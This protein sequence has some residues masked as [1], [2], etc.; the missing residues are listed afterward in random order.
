MRTH[1]GLDQPL[2]AAR[3][4]LL[5]GLLA[6]LGFNLVACVPQQVITP[7]P[8]SHWNDNYFYNYEPPKKAAPVSIRANVIIVNPS[9]KEAESAFADATYL[10]V[11]KGFSKSMGVDLDKIMVAKG[12][13]VVG[14]HATLDDVTYPDKKGADLTLAP[15]V[16][17]TADLKIGDSDNRIYNGVWHRERS[18]MMKIGGWVAYEMREPLSGRI[19]TATCTSGARASWSSA[20]GRRRWPTPSR[21]T[22][23]SSW[24]RPGPI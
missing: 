11:G 8:S 3:A 20:A 13:T 18:F 16:F 15:R 24:R 4:I 19:N 21:P 12:M 14:P 1:V 23:L 5:M 22:T 10:K 17:L 9:Y 2:A 7:L 6:T